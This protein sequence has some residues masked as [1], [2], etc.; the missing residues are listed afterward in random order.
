MRKMLLVVGVLALVAGC[1]QLDDKADMIEKGTEQAEK[2]APM[3]DPITGGWASR[4][5]GIVGLVIPAALAVNRQ[6]VA[7][8]RKKV[9]VEINEKSGTPDAVKQ[10]SSLAATKEV[11]KIIG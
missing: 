2:Y 6:I 9:I 3:A 11:A 4:V 1:T 5:A 8:R 10:V 7:S